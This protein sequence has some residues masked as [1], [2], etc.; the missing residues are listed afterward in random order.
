M[1]SPSGL[2]GEREAALVAVS[3]RFRGSTGAS[4]T[5]DS[6]V[7]PLTDEQTLNPLGFRSTMRES[8]TWSE[9]QDSHRYLGGNRVQTSSISTIRFASHLVVELRV[10]SF[11]LPTRWV[12]LEGGSRP[13]A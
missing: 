4:T 1:A 8:E 7:S 5:R 13:L 2:V 6:A 3:A 11:G 10:P 12:L 9:F